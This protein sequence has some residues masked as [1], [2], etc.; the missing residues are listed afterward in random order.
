[1]YGYH[2]PAAAADSD[3]FGGFLVVFKC[4]GVEFITYASI[5]VHIYWWRTVLSLS[6][7]FTLKLATRLI[8]W[9]KFNLLS[10]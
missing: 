8:L 7:K 2:L 4:T 10:N 9:H 3:F 1:M 5:S 6:V